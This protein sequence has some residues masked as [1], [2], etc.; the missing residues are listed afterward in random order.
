M[1]TSLTRCQQL[2]EQARETV[3]DSTF[4]S[5][6]VMDNM[7]GVLTPQQ[8][9][10][11]GGAVHACARACACACPTPLSVPRRR[12]PDRAI[13][14]RPRSVAAQVARFL[15][16]VEKHKRSMEVFNSITERG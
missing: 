2:V 12:R 14:V 6:Q 8:V 11:R 15:V 3:L 10:A 16:W 4:A 1:Q 5:Q 9:R 7:R 13:R